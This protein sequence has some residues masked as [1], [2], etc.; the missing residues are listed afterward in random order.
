MS[1]RPTFVTQDR[2]CEN[3]GQGLLDHEEQRY[4]RASG[5]AGPP[6]DP[7]AF[8]YLFNAAVSAAQKDNPAEHDYAAKRKAIFAHEA[9]LRAALA[10]AEQRARTADVV[11][12]KAR[13]YLAARERRQGTD[14]A[15]ST[16]A[17]AVWYHDRALGGGPEGRGSA[18]E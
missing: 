15:R 13:E 8:E 14:A 11:V 3:C 17:D 10:S 5:A 18:T 9:G 6:S 4:C 7:R 2:R 16:M 1:D 12:E